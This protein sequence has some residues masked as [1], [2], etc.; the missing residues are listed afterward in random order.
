MKT[1]IPICDIAIIGGGPVGAALALALRG[2]GWQ[3]SLLEERPIEN[4][5]ADARALALSYGSRLLLERLGLWAALSEV[6]PIRTIHI[7]QKDR[8][9]AYPGRSHDTGRSGPRS[10]A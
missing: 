4:T 3:V 7:S 1:S 8:A 6:T 2:S 10:G 5:V 9:P